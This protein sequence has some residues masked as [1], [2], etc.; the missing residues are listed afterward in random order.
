MHFNPPEKWVFDIFR[1]SAQVF[2][3]LTMKFLVWRCRTGTRRMLLYIF[4]HLVSF[5]SSVGMP[6]SFLLLSVAHT[7][8]CTWAQQGEVS[9]IY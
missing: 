2:C 5:G 9:A 8:H 1:F 4:G 6:P 3:K 7:A